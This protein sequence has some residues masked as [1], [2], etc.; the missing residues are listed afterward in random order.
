MW[1]GIFAKKYYIDRKKLPLYV[2]LVEYLLVKKYPHSPMTITS[3]TEFNYLLE[4][5]I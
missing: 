5:K 1:E 3:I 4:L 2:T